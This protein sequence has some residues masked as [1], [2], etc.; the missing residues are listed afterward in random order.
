MNKEIIS[1]NLNLRQMQAFS[2]ICLQ[3]FCIHHRIKHDSIDLLIIHLM[4]MLTAKN[5]SCWEQ[6]GANLAITGRGDLLPQDVLAVIPDA[7]IE[8][9]NKL[10]AYC[11]EVGIVDLYGAFTDQPVIFLEKCIGI[12]RKHKIKVPSIELL[13][14]YSRGTDTLGEVVNEDEFISILEAYSLVTR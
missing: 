5:I 6:Q 3:E 7:N 13:T 11:V 14:K 9:F 1:K 8:D 10:V 12:L 2:A 4:N